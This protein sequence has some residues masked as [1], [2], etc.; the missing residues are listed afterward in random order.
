MEHKKYLIDSNI[1]IA[2]FRKEE[3]DYKKANDLLFSFDSFAITEHVL[4]EIATILLL[5][6]G[7]EISKL[8]IQ[9]LK[10]CEKIN[11]LKLTEKEFCQIINCYPY[12][13][14]KLSMTDFSLLLLAKKRDFELISFDKELMKAYQNF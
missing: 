1:I 3:L 14:S 11:I 10:S 7:K 13:N 2:F 5:K 6:E 12:K 9:F 8:F 4:F